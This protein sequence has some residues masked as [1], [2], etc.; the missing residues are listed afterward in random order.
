MDD[1][2]PRPSTITI[3][4]TALALSCFVWAAQ[5][6]EVGRSEAW[7]ESQSIQTVACADSCTGPFTVHFNTRSVQCECH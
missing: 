3:V 2:R 1:V 5:S 6:C 4:F 7:R